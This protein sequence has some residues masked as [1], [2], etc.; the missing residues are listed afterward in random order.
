MKPEK[1]K[2]VAQMA[3]YGTDEERD[4]AKNIL[5]IAGI[6]LDDI[7][8]EEEIEV[9]YTFKTSLERQLIV[10]VYCKL[11]DKNSMSSLRLGNR[12][13]SVCLPKEKATQFRQDVSTILSLWRKELKRFHD[14]F[15]QANR[16]FSD[17]PGDDESESPLS[18]EE[19]EEIMDMARSIKRA[20]LGRLLKDGKSSGKHPR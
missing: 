17:T 15:I 8:A 14:G 18:I 6:S 5:E 4:V 10:Q 19:I 12:K 9:E 2:L 13:G 1:M 20:T 11:M 7:E 16:L 3:R